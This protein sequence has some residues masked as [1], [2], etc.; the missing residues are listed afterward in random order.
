MDARQAFLCAVNEFEAI[1]LESSKLGDENFDANRRRGIELRRLMGEKRSAIDRLAEKAFE[2]PRQ[3]Q[4]FRSF[5]NDMRT[6]MAAHHAAWPLVSIDL[7]NPAYRASIRQSRD[8]IHH[9]ITWA[10]TTLGE[11]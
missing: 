1:I 3:L 7:A 4:Q 2:D 6:A 10:R 5:F 11:G 8:A 9:F